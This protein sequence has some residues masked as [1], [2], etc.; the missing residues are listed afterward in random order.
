M[1]LFLCVCINTC[2]SMIYF[3]F[4]RQKNWDVTIIPF[5]SHTSLMNYF[6]A[7]PMQLTRE[8]DSLRGSPPAQPFSL[9]EM[10]WEPGE[11]WLEL[12]SSLAARWGALWGG[13]TVW[14]ASRVRAGLA[15]AGEAWIFMHLMTAWLIALMGN[16]RLKMQ[17]FRASLRMGISTHVSSWD[18]ANYYRIDRVRGRLD[19][20]R[21]RPILRFHRWAAFKGVCFSQTGVAGLRE[22]VWNPA[23]CAVQGVVHLGLTHI[24]CNL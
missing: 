24:V 3:F 23:A 9:Q 2:W 5:H 20:K 21:L 22:S 18:V 13:R 4:L 12:V 10:R 1:A 8:T 19:P 16:C 14:A 6:K 7:I 17:G 11:T 15:G